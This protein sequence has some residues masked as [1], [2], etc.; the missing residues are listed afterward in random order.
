M[1]KTIYLC[2]LRERV[3]KEGEM[4][5]FLPPAHRRLAHP[6]TG[7]LILST[8]NSLAA[9]NKS[10]GILGSP[11]GAF[12]CGGPSHFSSLNRLLNC[13]Y[14]IG[15]VGWLCLNSGGAFWGIAIPTQKDGASGSFHTGADPNI[16]PQPGGCH[17]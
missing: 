3:G 6:T 4:L 8:V 9:Q 11:P 5:E 14:G 13:S 1:V 16:T 7:A 15:A 10:L 12:G 2:S 17:G